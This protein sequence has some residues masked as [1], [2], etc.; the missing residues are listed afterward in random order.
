MIKSDGMK[1]ENQ[2][3]FFGFVASAKVKRQK[4]KETSELKNTW[5]NP[6]KYRKCTAYCRLKPE[7]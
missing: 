5:P 3:L 1:R 6:L 2:D 4:G 7:T